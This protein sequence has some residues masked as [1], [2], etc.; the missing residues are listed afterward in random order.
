MMNS[1]RKKAAAIDD[2]NDDFQEIE[3]VGPA[4]AKA[5]Y[6]IGVSVFADLA[7]FSTLAELQQVLLEKGGVNVPIWKIENQKGEKGDWLQQAGKLAQFAKNN[8]SSSEADAKRRTDDW[9]EHAYFTLKFEHKTDEDGQK[10]WRT[11]I[12]REQNGGKE[13][14]LPGITDRW[15]H[16]ILDHANLPPNLMSQAK[17]ISL[18]EVEKAPVPEEPVPA[19]RRL[20]IKSLKLHVSDQSDKKPQKQIAANLQFEVSGFD[21]AQTSVSLPLHV[22]LL[23][24]NSETNHTQL[25]ASDRIQLEQQVNNYSS[26]LQFALPKLGH[27]QMHCVLFLPTIS[28]LAAHY[29]GPML[30]I[31][32]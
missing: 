11:W 23:L 32:P 19:K 1:G 10:R 8:G 20:T 17:A 25:V 7:R 15:V 31:I 27:Y 22:E 30:N 13:V 26:Q 6:K 18:V 14:E 21:D 12:Y 9:R 4:Y 3:G 28:E 2:I 16:W 24:V 29:Q 5:L